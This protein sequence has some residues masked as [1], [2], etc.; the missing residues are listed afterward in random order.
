[1]MEIDNVFGANDEAHGRSKLPEGRTLGGDR[2]K[3]SPPVHEIRPSMVAPR[4]A[5]VGGSG[6]AAII[7]PVPM[8]QSQLIAKCEEDENVWVEAK[9]GAEGESESVIVFSKCGC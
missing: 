8:V 4:S 5:G 3:V 6:P 9:N 2:P 1:M 7:L